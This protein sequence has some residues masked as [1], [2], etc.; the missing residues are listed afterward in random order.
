MSERKDRCETCRFWVEE[1][2][3]KKGPSDPLD[4]TDEPW[5][6][7]R[8]YPPVLIEIPANL[9]QGGS[10]QQPITMPYDW[11]GEWQAKPTT[12]DKDTCSS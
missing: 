5:G 6:R 2:D 12:E 10:C 7:C 1:F 8:R 3:G 9:Y 11:C 4:D